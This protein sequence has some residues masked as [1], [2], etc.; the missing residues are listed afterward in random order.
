MI[1]N[2]VIQ[3]G[4]WFTF[5]SFLINAVSFFITPLFARLLTKGEYGDFS[6]FTSWLS[7]IFVV[8]SLNLEASL[9]R[10]RFDFE[11]DLDRYVLSMAS[12]SMLSTGIWFIVVM[13]F[14]DF[15]SRLLS[16]D[17]TYLY[18]MFAYLFF[19]PVVNL[20]MAHQRFQYRYKA[21]VACSMLVSLGASFLAVVLVVFMDDK[22]TGRVIGYV[23]PSALV[24][25]FLLG[26]YIQKGRGIRLRYWRFALAYSLPFIPHLL[27]MFLLEGMD[28]VMVRK[29]CDAQ[30]LGLYSLAYVVGNLITVLVLAVNN[31]Y[32]PWLGEQMKGEQFHWIRRISF[33]Y[34]V[35]FTLCTGGIVLLMPEI[36]YIMGGARYMEAIYV[37]PPVAAACLL[38]F[39]YSMYVDVEQFEKKTI[40]MAVASMLAAG[41]NFVLNLILIPR[42]GYL[43]AAYTTYAGYFF[44][45]VTLFNCL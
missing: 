17:V 21:S 34:A 44:L 41:L 23:L 20:F 40:G 35:C 7:I 36:L 39:I 12:L 25:A 32:V 8:T 4:V 3:S 43:A 33:P 45:M 19:M 14:H 42:F 6:N 18:W 28:K 10:A 5:S 22:M 16:I 1:K 30:S 31:A 27:S 37:M 24:G 13:L 26:Y 2:K 38:Q 15:F 11:Q 9:I 29:M